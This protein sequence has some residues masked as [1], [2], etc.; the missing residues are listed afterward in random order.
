MT[1]GSSNVP[2]GESYISMKGNTSLL[3]LSTEAALAPT[4]PC[5][6]RGVVQGQTLTGLDFMQQLSVAR[7]LPCLLPRT[8]MACCLNRLFCCNLL[9]LVLNHSFS[10]ASQLLSLSTQSSHRGYLTF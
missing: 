3:G 8:G 9:T 1:L 2:R 7:R 10:Q 6:L 5:Q 4:T